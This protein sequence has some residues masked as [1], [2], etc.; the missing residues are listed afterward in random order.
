MS[1]YNAKS[2]DTPNTYLFTKF[3]DDLNIVDDSVYLTSLAECTCPA[4]SRASCRHRQMLPQ[5]LASQRID[6]DWFYCFETSDW[7]QPFESLHDDDA[8]IHSYNSDEAAPVVSRDDGE[9]Y[10]PDPVERAIDN[11]IEVEEQLAARLAPPAVTTDAP[12]ALDDSVPTRADGVDRF[13]GTV[14]IPHSLK[15][16]LRRL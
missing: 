10:N 12:A 1:L 2:T 16:P 5:F 7:S 13:E 8:V 14:V 15:R 4:G 9:Q 3:D 11:A 6:T